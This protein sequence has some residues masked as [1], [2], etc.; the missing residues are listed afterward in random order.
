[1]IVSYTPDQIKPIRQLQDKLA[2][3]LG[4]TDVPQIQYDPQLAAFIGPDAIGL[5]IL[6]DVS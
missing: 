3:E 6:D 1:M 2:L 5:V 4:L